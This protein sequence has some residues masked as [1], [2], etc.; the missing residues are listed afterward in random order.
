MYSLQDAGPTKDIKVIYIVLLFVFI[1]K[2]VLL[3][4]IYVIKWNRTFHIIFAK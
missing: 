1:K 3:F 4:G 2:L